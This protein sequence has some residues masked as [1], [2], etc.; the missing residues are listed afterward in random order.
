MKRFLT[1]GTILISA[2]TASGCSLAKYG[3]N[4]TQ[5]I[6]PRYANFEISEAT[7]SQNTTIRAVTYNIRFAKK[8]DEAVDILSSHPELAGA[9]IL[10]L[11]EMDERGVE[12][13]ARRL[14]Y[15]Y[16]YYP[17]VFHPIPQQNF[18]NAILSKWPILRDDKIIL[19]DDEADDKKLQRIAASALLDVNGHNVLVFSIH[20]HISLKPFVRSFQMKRILNSVPDNVEH[21]IVAGDFN[22]FTQ[23]GYYA[24]LTPMEEN[25][26]ELATKELGW[27]YRYWYTANRKFA[28]DHIFTKNFETV[29]A[30]KII[31]RS[32]S[33]HI[34][35]WV[36]LSIND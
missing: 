3:I 35:V 1:L 30:G 32:A 33:D 31:D 14:G 20:M 26:F 10:L 7:A 23:V 8:I 28:L 34:P 16:V 12:Q 11:Q 6:E 15:N 5:T 24:V 19:P 18:G 13:I 27:T 36:E 9:D 25:G 21:C 17:A 22:T 29:N 4:Y 2:L